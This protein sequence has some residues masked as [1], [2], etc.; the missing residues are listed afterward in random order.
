MDIVY[1]ELCNIAGMENVT[2]SEDM[3]NHTTFKAGG[4]AKY[5]V[6]PDNMERLS[7]LIFY[8]NKNGINHYVMG[9]GSNLLVRDEGFDG[10]IVK[11]GSKLGN[12]RIEDDAMFCDAGA[13]VSKAANMAGEE[14][15]S[16]LEF[17]AGI[18]G[19]IGGA[20][21]MNAG[22]YGGEFGNII[23]HVCVLDG[24]G[25]T[26]CLLNDQMEF[27]YRSSIIQKKGYIVTAVKLKLQH[28]NQ[29]DIIKQMNQYLKERREKQPLEFPSAGSTFKRPNGYYAGKLIMD[30]GLAGLQVG[31]ACVSEKH[32][33]FI[34]NKQNATAG[35]IIELM[36]RVAEIVFEKFS[37]KLEP[38]VKII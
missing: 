4:H 2:L 1:E 33:G 3:R 8:L 13:F 32:C 24:K 7:E 16:G 27:G 18:P 25:D 31:G 26:F 11:I 10:V 38:E 19:M 34:I 5:F 14:S 17:A 22:A 20:A 28:G 29:E 36:N 30:A 12:I 35:D 6:C 37:V 15:L 9:N 21:A 23:E